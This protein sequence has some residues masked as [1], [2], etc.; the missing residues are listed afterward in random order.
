LK[1]DWMHF[2]LWIRPQTYEGQGVECDGLNEKR[3]HRP[4]LIYLNTWFLV[5]GTIWEELAVMVLL[6]RM[7]AFQFQKPMPFPIISLYL[8]HVDKDVALSYCSKPMPACSHALHH[9]GHELQP[10]ET[11]SPK[12]NAFFK[13]LICF[14]HGILSQH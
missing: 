6:R 7:Q 13:K 4:M 8:L 14:G 2:A 11:V 3:P 12:F 5:G 1:L 9:D 10:S